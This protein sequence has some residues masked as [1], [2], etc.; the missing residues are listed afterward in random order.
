ML[1]LSFFGGLKEGVDVSGLVG[2][3]LMEVLTLCY[4]VSCSPLL[5]GPGVCFSGTKKRLWLSFHY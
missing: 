2:W 1:N 3:G 4:S 5:E